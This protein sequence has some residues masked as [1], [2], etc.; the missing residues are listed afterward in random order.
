MRRTCSH[1]CNAH[2]ENGI[3]SNPSFTA[4][5]LI[6]L[7]GYGFV[8]VGWVLCID[9]IRID[10]M[11]ALNFRHY[12]QWW[13]CWLRWRNFRK[14]FWILSS[15]AELVQSYEQKL[16]A[17]PH[18][19]LW[20][21]GSTHFMWWQVSGSHKYFVGFAQPG[22]WKK[23][24]SI[25]VKRNP[26]VPIEW[27]PHGP[28]Q[29][30]SRQWELPREAPFQNVCVAYWWTSVSLVSCS[31]QRTIFISEQF[32]P[33]TTAVQHLHGYSATRNWTSRQLNIQTG[34]LL[35]ANL[36]NVFSLVPIVRTVYR[37]AQEIPSIEC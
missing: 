35:R 14:L 27:K 37:Y 19:V 4:V 29:M 9:S 15:S 1:L 16:E 10:I 32:T 8:C 2:T 12:T 23:T 11:A 17:S 30:S 6:Y 13:C 36:L 21:C 5:T 24:V 33:H 34:M 18:S 3:S 25:K 31:N 26:F 22:N 20:M 28:R 7:R